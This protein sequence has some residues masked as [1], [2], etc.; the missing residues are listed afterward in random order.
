[1][2]NQNARVLG[3]VGARELTMEEVEKINGGAFT[4]TLRITHVGNRFDTVPDFDA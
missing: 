2:S 1:M 3:R 4:Q